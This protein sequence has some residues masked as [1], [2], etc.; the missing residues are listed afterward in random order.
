M[1]GEAQ[2]TQESVRPQ[3]QLSADRTVGDDPL[4]SSKIIK[5]ETILF[6]SAPKRA[7]ELYGKSL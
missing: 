1:P 7:V 6:H 3:P 2:H 4:I 5:E